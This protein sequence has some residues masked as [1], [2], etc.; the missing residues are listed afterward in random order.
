M[1]IRPYVYLDSHAYADSYCHANPDLYSD[2]YAY[3]DPGSR[4]NVHG[5]AGCS[6]YARSDPDTS[7]PTDGYTGTTTD[8]YSS[9]DGHAHTPAD[10]DA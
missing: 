3:S 5:P 2:A 1:R 7:P 8:P 10:R 9:T 4:H 6:H